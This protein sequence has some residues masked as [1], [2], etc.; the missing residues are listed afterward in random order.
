MK[1]IPAW[2]LA[3]GLLSILLPAAPPAP[4]CRTLA[5]EAERLC[6]T[7]PREALA[8]IEAARRCLAGHEDPRLACRLTGIEGRAR[9]N[10]GDTAAARQRFAEQARQADRLGD[11]GLKAA[12]A[13]D[14]GL[15]EKSLS[16]Y[17][18]AA[19]ACRRGLELYE[20]IG[21][22]SGTAQALNQLGNIAD[23][24]GQ[25]YQAIDD[26]LR[27]LRLAE[28]L[29]DPGRIARLQNNIGIIHFKLKEYDA[30][31][32]S[33]GQAMAFEAGQGNQRRLANLENN[34][35]LVHFEQ[36]HFAEAAEHYRRALELERRLGSPS[37]V[38][39]SLTSLGEVEQ[40][41]GK[42]E[43]AIALYRQAL[44]L[45]VEARDSWG[46]ALIHADL[47]A[48]LAATGRLAEAHDEA[49]KSLELARTTAAPDL[50][51][52]SRRALADIL[53]RRG[54]PVEALTQFRA[55]H[56]LY[57]RTFNDETR[58]RTGDLQARYEAERHRREVEALRQQQTIQDLQAD[59]NRLLIRALG[60]GLL[61]LA[62]LVVVVLGNLRHKARAN[63]LIAH[64]NEE[65]TDAYHRLEEAART[66]PLT[67][68]ANRRDVHER[69]ENERVRSERS[70]KAFAIVLSDID[71]FKAINDRWGHEAGDRVLVAVAETMRRTL[72]KQDVV[73]RWGGEEFIWVL[74][75]TPLE[76]A[77]LLAEK[78]RALIHEQSVRLGETEIRVTLT[79]GVSAYDH[80][81]DFEH[82]IRLADQAL[83]RGKEAGRDR[84]E[85][86]APPLTSPAAG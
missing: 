43:Q 24:L 7:A 67:R 46:E 2:I 56:D 5:G 54:R 82:C 41:L 57:E 22:R 16:R 37:G 80:P 30:A 19:A 86:A 8:K 48:S 33:Y 45:A 70:H 15:L 85:V 59:R 51:M 42:P 3:A 65:L 18:E 63:A 79:F 62:A 72:R 26:Y 73:G 76:G 11:D 12:A 58:R 4:D 84:V 74:P 6:D 69:L 64:Q 77:R 60:L 36:K 1:R 13:L 28:Q 66:D 39:N 32:A 44:P 78:I 68:L 83:Y 47:A 71:H 55:Y 31:L 29:G 50:E 52:T 40:A 75:E 53:A 10:L 38:G 17:P 23:D 61:L 35:G 49:E 81:M 20:R 14:Q 34:I 21:D 25:Y 27:S 9:L